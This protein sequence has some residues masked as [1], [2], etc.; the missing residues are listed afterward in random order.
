VLLLDEWLETETSAVISKV[1]VS[2]TKLTRAGAVCC[3]ATHKLERWNAQNH[4]HMNM[5]S[6]S[7][8]SL[9]QPD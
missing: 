3:V 5:L 4:S 2:L 9:R 8:V 7:V 1:L 6:G